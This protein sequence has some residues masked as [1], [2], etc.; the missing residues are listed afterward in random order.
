[1]CFQLSLSMERMK[2]VSFILP[3]SHGCIV[4][5]LPPEEVS[6]DV[7]SDI[8]EVLYRSL[9]RQ[10]DDFIYPGKYL[11]SFLSPGMC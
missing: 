5:W 6:V 9:V 7:L 4:P 2:D 10:I 8:L 1:M 11:S 3:K